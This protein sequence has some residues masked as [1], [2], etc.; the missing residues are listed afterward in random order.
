MSSIMLLWNIM[1]YNSTL[2]MKKITNRC[3]NMNELQRHYAELWQKSVSKDYI[4]Y[5]SILLY[6]GKK[7][8]ET[9]K[10]FSVCQRLEVEG[11]CDFKVAVQGNFWGDNKIIVYRLCG[12][13]INLHM[14]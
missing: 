9:K 2:E 12:I 5:D 11:E 8:S 1:E 6:S 7:N 14:C 3:G 13:Y 10:L 4:W